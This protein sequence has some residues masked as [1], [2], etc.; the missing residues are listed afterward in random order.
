M[1]DEK[2]S[3]IKITDRRKFNLDGTPR[4]GADEQEAERPAAVAPSEPA[5]APSPVE[6]AKS[7][8]VLSFPGEVDRKRSDAQAEAPP[9]PDGARAAA[10]AEMSSPNEMASAAEQAYNTARQKEPSTIP[11]ASF[12]SLLNMLGVQA[13]M[14]LGLIQGPEGGTEAI[15]LEAARH[16]ID[17]LGIVEAKTS[18]NLTREEE[19]LLENILAD[20]RMQFVALSRRR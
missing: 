4:E 13:A 2:E 17:M 18:G 3:G 8:N 12:L 7:E 20:L 11:D 16:M 1:V 10:R 15:D 9:A 5:P 14:H 6:E 19:A